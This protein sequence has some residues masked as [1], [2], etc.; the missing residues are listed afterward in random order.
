[1]P[2]PLIPIAGVVAKYGAV[3]LAAW[4]VTRQVERGRTDQRAEDAM[5]D[6]PDGMTAHH[7][8]DRGQANATAKWR[9]VVRFGDGGPAFEIAAAAMGR[10]SVRR[11]AP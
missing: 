7:A 3:A 11:V 5:D 6:L 10:F 2:V 4:A 9:R 8:R 1:M